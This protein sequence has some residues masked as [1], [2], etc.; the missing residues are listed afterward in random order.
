MNEHRVHASRNLQP[1]GKHNPAFK[2]QKK[3]QEAVG[4]KRYA[5][6][7]IFSSVQKRG[8]SRIGS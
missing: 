6:Q 4:G 8:F 1:R 7:Y 5:E 2:Q 3:N